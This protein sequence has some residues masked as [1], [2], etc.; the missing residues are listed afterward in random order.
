MKKFVNNFNYYVFFFFKELNYCEKNPDT[1]GP[2]R[3]VS[4]AA[5][6]GSYECFCP[7]GTY[8]PN[9]LTIDNSTISEGPSDVGDFPMGKF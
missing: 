1:C 5:S 3:C 4:R 9:C 2:G 7:P 8:P 6:E